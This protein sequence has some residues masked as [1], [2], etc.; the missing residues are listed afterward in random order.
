MFNYYMFFDYS[1]YDVIVIDWELQWVVGNMKILLKF[2]L[3]MNEGEIFEL[4]VLFI[5]EFLRIEKN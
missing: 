2:F 3:I 1:F 4:L 5:E